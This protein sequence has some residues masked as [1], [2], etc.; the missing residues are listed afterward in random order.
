MSGR[1]IL[2][3]RLSEETPPA[4]RIADDAEEVPPVPP[5][6]DDTLN[7]LRRQ[8]VQ[9]VKRICP[10]WLSSHQEDIV[11]AS[12]IRVLQVSSESGGSF[13]TS[14]LWKVVFNVT[15]DEIRRQRRRPEGSLDDSETN[16]LAQLTPGPEQRAMGWQLGRAIRHCLAG[17]GEDRRLAVTLH[18]QGHTVPE[19]GRFL[20]WPTKRVAN[21]TYRGIGD[22]RRCL[23][24]KG[25]TP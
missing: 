7:G 22:L 8:L 13:S 11:Q 15:V 19:A 14:Y 18:L 12:M 24:A 5:I 2:H 23:A 21:L 16:E 3:R 9:V 10:A 6:E 1:Q 25:F 4:P 20:G 17:L